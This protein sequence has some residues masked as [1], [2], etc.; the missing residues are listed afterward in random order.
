MISLYF[1]IPF[2]QKKC[3]Y[4]HF[5]VLPNRES[6]SQIFQNALLKEWNL[7]LPFIKGK[8]IISLYFGGGTPSLHP[9]II[10]SVLT[11]VN[12]D[13]EME[14]TVEVNPEQLTPQLAYNL[15]KIGVNR[16]SLGVQS[17][18]DSL[19]KILGR[20]HTSQMSIDA[21]HTIFN[22][23][24]K[25]ITIDLM[26]ELPYQTL[27]SWE[28]TLNLTTTLPIT[29]LS[30]YNLTFEPKT[31]FEKK[32]KE[33]RP[34]LP[35]EEVSIQMLQMAIEKLEKMG[36]QRYEISAFAKKGF[37]SIHNSGYWTNR[38]F[39]GFGPSAFSYWEGQRFRNICHLKR[40]SKKLQL[41]EFPID[42]EEKLSKPAHLHEQIA[43]RLRLC[44]GINRKKISI[45]ETAKNILD[46]LENEGLIKQTPQQIY[47]TKQ[48]LLFYDT[49]A[50]RIIL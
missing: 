35:S 27:Q 40:Y 26:N 18:D 9:A 47:L 24:I 28:K 20:N 33:L 10:E 22:A 13:S 41:N 45:P 14:I 38:P 4:C 5:F 48:G 23:G 8:K 30:L 19:L 36:L 44:K 16:V 34:H 3:P 37:E 42:F 32:A 6:D 17:L 50:E 7:R 46:E 43:I 15:K 12:L 49:V 2:C 11:K 1:H 25:N 31:V 39:L 21:I 29:H